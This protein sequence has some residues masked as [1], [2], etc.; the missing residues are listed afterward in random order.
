VNI[1]PNIIRALNKTYRIPNK[2]SISSSP[3]KKD[4]QQQN[5]R[6]MSEEK[7]EKDTTAIS[8]LMI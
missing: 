5:V 2:M 7:E 4:E 1:V 8:N 6:A 3:N